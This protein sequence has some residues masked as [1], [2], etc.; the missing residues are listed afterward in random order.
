MK[1]E[2]SKI[3]K[4]IVTAIRYLYPKSILLAIPNEARRNV[5]TGAIMK[6][7]GMLSGTSDLIFIHKGSVY[8]FE[9]KTDNGKQTDTQ[10]EFEKRITKQGLKYFVVRS[11]DEVLNIIVEINTLN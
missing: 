4:A 7:M 3:Q 5:R 1:H 8:F 6:A 11:V 9:V 10:K 2:E